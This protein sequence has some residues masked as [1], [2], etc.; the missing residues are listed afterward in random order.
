MAH[1]Y[2]PR[3]SLARASRLPRSA[4]RR[5]GVNLERYRH[6]TRRQRE[7]EVELSRALATGHDLASLLDEIRAGRR[8]RNFHWAATE[9]AEIAQS[10]A[11][12]LPDWGPRTI[13]NA[14]RIAGHVV[15]LLGC[16]ALDLG[17]DLPW[18]ED[19]VNG[20]RWEPR[21][22]Y[23]Q[24]TVPI[25]RADIKI[26]WELSRCQHLPTLGM[27]FALTREERFAREVVGQIRDWI[28]E[29]PPGYGVNWACTMD[30]AIRAVNWIWAVQLIG[31]SGASDDRFLIE[32]LASLVAHGRH[33]ARNIEVYEGG[34]T[35]NHT[36]ADYVGMLY[37]AAL[38][39]EVRESEEW[40]CRALEGTADCMRVQILPDG[41]A[42]ENSIAYH[43]LV[44]EL[45]LGAFLIARRSGRGLPDGYAESLE[46][47][48]EFVLD[49]TRPD[50]LAPMIGDSDDGR[51]QIL[52]DYF[53]WNPQDHRY[54]LAIGGALFD[55]DDFRAAAAG[56]PGAAES[57]AWM[58]G[59]AAATDAVPV[60][61]PGAQRRSRAFESAGRYIM[62]GRDSYVIVSVDEVGTAGLGNHK[63]NDALSFELAVGG[64]TLIVDP[65]S[66]AYT[67]DPEVRDAFR[68]TRAHNTLCMDGVEQNEPLGPFGMHPDASVVVNSWTSGPGSDALDAQHSGYARLSDPVV[69]R[70]LLVLRKQPFGYLVLDRLSCGADHDAE[71]FLHFAPGATLTGG[72]G[73]TGDVRETAHA[74]AAAASAGEEVADLALGEAL[75]CS[76]EGVTVHLVPFGQV[77][78]T[79]ADGWVAPRYGRRVRAPVV[80]MRARISGDTRFGYLLVRA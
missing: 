36:L 7:P 72:Q 30:V 71:S 5:A 38:V 46:S 52:S 24:V 65:G 22:F 55:R 16:D 79:V 10:L 26:P 17:P 42:Y 20:Y 43:R 76:L 18:H 8:Q 28:A 41:A 9:A 12:R 23:K 57:V 35:T 64:V 2:R 56:A 27:A 32:Y 34:V 4:V 67:G 3:K 69:H 45:F 19:P 37:I 1:P 11:G 70:R 68:G 29:N 48:F 13:R 14:D 47:M 21:A 73:V 75:T 15:R 6:R 53:D 40:A 25:G 39:P 31:G 61:G 58:L 66:Y 78:T 74:L 59:S 33:I 44:L 80:R 63:H 54:L 51:L 77:E 50:G 49:Y 62:R 60:P